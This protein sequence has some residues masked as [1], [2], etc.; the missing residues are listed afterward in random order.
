[1]KAIYLDQ[2]AGYEALQSGDIPQPRPAA[3]EILIRVHA[4]AITPTEFD[5]FPTFNTAEGKPRAFPII[6]SHEFSGVVAEL[7][8]GVTGFNPGDVVYGMNDW[9]ANGAQAEFC[10]TTPAAIALKP[11]LITHAQATTV[12]ISA[13]T[14]WQGLFDHAK[15]VANQRVLIHG[16]AGG[17]GLFAVQLA[18]A[19]G[20]HVIATASAH[21]LEFVRSLGAD[22]VIDYKNERFEDRARELDV[23]FDTIGG[24][25][26]HR[27][28]TVLKPGGKLVTVAAQSER[29]ARAQ[30]AFFIVEPR[31]AQLAEIAALLDTGKLQSF[32]AATFPLAQ[33]RDAYIHARRGGMKGKVAIQVNDGH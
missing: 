24:E 31:G 14:A 16:G 28:W 13:L 20:A 22:E 25:T 3:G 5:W 17:V 12:P 29:D 30:A 19:R 21:N 32:V 33:T 23:V 8:A 1:M 15:L 27:S 4:T 6:Q 26:L 10:I 11:K 9:F 18:H 7:G 2:T